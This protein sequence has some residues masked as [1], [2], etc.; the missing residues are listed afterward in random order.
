MTTITDTQLLDWLQA[1]LDEAHYTG[2][3]I[4]RWSGYGRGWRLHES[5]S[6]DACADVRTAIVWGMSGL[7]PKPESVSGEFEASSEVWTEVP[8]TVPSEIEPDA[9]DVIYAPLGRLDCALV[10]NG[11]ILDAD[12]NRLA[13]LYPV[14]PPWWRLFRRLRWCARYRRL[15]L[16]GPRGAFDADGVLRIPLDA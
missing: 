11:E 14:P 8:A 5:S 3:C 12:N 9:A 10:V 7:P 1:Q 2:R 16:R 6:D 13:L 15:T 4:F